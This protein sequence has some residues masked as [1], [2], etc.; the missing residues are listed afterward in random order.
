MLFEVFHI[1]DSFLMPFSDTPTCTSYFYI[2]LNFF[3]NIHLPT[4]RDNEKNVAVKK[5]NRYNR[6]LT[7]TAEWC[8]WCSCFIPCRATRK[9]HHA[10]IPY[11]WGNVPSRIDK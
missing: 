4:I 1:G 7:I 2:E 10:E 9:L 6:L 5:Q 8:I 11:F 3:Q